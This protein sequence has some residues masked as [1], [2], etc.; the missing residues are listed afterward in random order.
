[1]PNPAL[2]DGEPIVGG[3][4]AVLDETV[5]MLRVLEEH[6]V[7]AHVHAAQVGRRQQA[8]ARRRLLRCTV[9]KLI[10]DGVAHL[11]IESRTSRDD[12]RD[13]ADL[14]DFFRESEGGGA[15]FR[16]DWRSKREPVLWLADA[17]GGAVHEHLVGRS[18]GPFDR[19][20]AIKLIDQIV[21]V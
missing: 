6:G 1:M 16:Y 19:L 11:I 17:I 2:A 3:P 5:P 15:P 12:G 13:Q 18:D 14:L 8:I 21:Y 4:I 9:P 7:V 10:E 20:K